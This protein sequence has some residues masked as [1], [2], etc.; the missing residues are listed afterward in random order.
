MIDGGKEIEGGREGEGEGNGER[1]GV[2]VIITSA[3]NSQVLE[4]KGHK[5]EGKQ[6]GDKRR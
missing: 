4:L 5:W 3:Q 1:G 6:L 2:L